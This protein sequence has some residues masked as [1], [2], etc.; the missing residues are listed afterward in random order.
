MSKPFAALVLSAVV[1]ATLCLSSPVRAQ[2]Q[3]S[4]G[5]ARGAPTVVLE[6]GLGDGAGSWRA[7]RAALPDDLAV[8]AWSRAGY[9]GGA[10]TWASDADG[11]RTG[12]EVAARLDERMAAAGVRPPY[13]LVSH[14]IG[15]Y[16]AL[17]FARAHP[18]QVAGMVFVDPRLP[19]FNR[20]CKAEGLRLCEIPRLLMLALSPTERAELA[21]LEETEA[22]LA[23]L[24]A[25]RD[26]PVVILTAGRGSPG[27]DSRMRGLWRAYADEFAARFSNARRIEAPTSGHYIHRDDT[28][29]V[30]AEILRLTREP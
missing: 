1:L 13:V 28:R 3:A 11:R 22:E 16:Y 2:A 23:D 30:A 7:L 12:A 24:S 27:E 10:L 17:S 6:A 29:R 4:S 15:A 18:D 25:L 20:R 26:I 19:G 5:P 14:S 8:F 9:P 21:G